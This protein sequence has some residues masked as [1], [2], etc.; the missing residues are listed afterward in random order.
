MTLR[1]KMVPELKQVESGES[2]IIT[3]IR[4]YAKYFPAYDMELV[5]KE[6]SEFDLYA[7]HA[8]MQDARYPANIA[9]VAHCHG[10][11]WTS[12]YQASQWEWSANADVI[13]SLRHAHA[14]TVPS[15]WVAET[16][17]RDMHR[18]PVVLPHGVDWDEWQHKETKQG[19]VIGYAKNRAGQD[20]CNPAYLN[21]LASSFP[22]IEFLSTFSP[23]NPPLNITVTGVFPYA[24]NKQTVQ[25]ADV[26][27]SCTR[28][29]FGIAI[30]EAMAAGLPILGWREGGIVDLVQH[31]INGYLAQPY[32]YADLVQGM[33]YCIQHRIALGANGREMARKWTWEK[34]CAQVANIYQSA[35]QKAKESAT[36][37]VIIPSFN[38]S[39]KVGVALDS[40]LQQTYPQLTDIIVVDDCSPDNGATGKVV[41]EYAEHDPRVRYIR[42]EQNSGVATARNVG[43]Y[44]VD[45]KYVCCLDSDDRILPQFLEVCIPP[46]EKDHSLG[47]SFTSM[48]AVTPDGKIYQTR[49]PPDMPLFDLQLEG[50]NQVPTC[51]VFRRE[52]WENLGGYRARYAPEG[53]GSEDAEFWLR[54]GANGGGYTK[55]S[56]ARM[57]RYSLGGNTT[58]NRDYKEPNWTSMHPWTKDKQ[59]PIASLATAARGSHPARIYDT[60]AISVIIPVGPG[61]ELDIIDAVDSIEA[62]DFRMW[63]VIL[64]LDGVD[65]QIIA[66]VLK[67]YPF[68]RVF[69]TENGPRGAGVARNLGAKNARA[70]LLVFLDG[71]DYLLPAALSSMLQEFS[72]EESIVY[73]DCEAYAIIDDVTKLDERMQKN[74]LERNKKTKKT[75]IRFP[76]ADYNCELAQSMPNSDDP[77]S[78]YL[79]AHVTCLL[80][81]LWHDAIGGFDEEMVSWED[82]DWHWRLSKA[83]YCYRRLHQDIF[84]YQLSSGNRREKGRQNWQSLLQYLKDKHGGLKN[85]PCKSCGGGGSGNPP[86][87][88]KIYPGEI[89]KENSMARFT[90][91]Q[92]VLAEYMHPNRGQHEVVGG[93]TKTKYGY[94]GGG[95]VFMVHIDDIAAQPMYF[96][97][98]R[99]DNV[100]VPKADVQLPPP[101]SIINSAQSAIPTPAPPVQPETESVPRDLLADAV[102]IAKPPL[103]ELEEMEINVI[104]GVTQAISKQMRERGITTPRAIMDSGIEGLQELK[105]VGPNRAA[106]IVG[107][108]AGRV[109]L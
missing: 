12:M 74:I 2:G 54:I 107:W 83:G 46:L 92:I 109:G 53:C 36:C 99:L 13:N 105:G 85:M 75:Y 71:D 57:F 76:A 59:H 5:G 4:K 42:L 81:K 61:H 44:N 84:V 6:T 22:N 18:S 106:A 21:S 78:L 73:G 103:D 101:P 62:Q 31:G 10:V 100:I 37:A 26:F 47:I 28:E 87:I 23:E 20:V 80:P 102:E 65:E 63:E 104:P 51:C 88:K 25:R 86:P 7:V 58:K 68:A 34:V 48:D 67:S 89:V 72:K 77:E 95:E 33:A 49:W 40:A 97:Q 50:Q 66:P 27:V 43:I 1:V 70:G 11:Y 38:Y 96:R 94:R 98:V 19:Y 41:K 35:I 64:A 56:T 45:T 9:T 60:P 69:R 29:T 3:I 52:A 15:T 17:Q 93:A 8:G 39:A 90:D 108:V 82:V 14:I 24:Q 79:V 16:I 91:D 55:A 30:L 32:D